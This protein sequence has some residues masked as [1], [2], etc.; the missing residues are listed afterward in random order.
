MKYMFFG[1]ALIAIFAMC[2]SDEPLKDD[3]QN[4]TGPGNDTTGPGNDTTGPGNDT[5]EMPTPILSKEFNASFLK[6]NLTIWVEA[7]NFSRNWTFFI[8]EDEQD[9]R[10]GF[11]K[12]GDRALG[13]DI[14]RQRFDCP[15]YEGEYCKETN[16]LI[17][18]GVT[19]KNRIEKGDANIA[20]ST[21]ELGC[22]HTGYS[23]GSSLLECTL[24]NQTAYRCRTKE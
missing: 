5:N 9:R 15:T 11:F 24:G 3:G 6:A 18:G 7:I 20:F 12:Y 16:L 19:S 13:C 2:V 14:N 8:P 21:E 22:S 23:D 17:C 4:T 10:C 1:L